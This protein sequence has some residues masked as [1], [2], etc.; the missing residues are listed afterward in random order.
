MKTWLLAFVIACAAADLSGCSSSSSSS[1]AARPCYGPGC[2]AAGG[3]KD[4][5]TSVVEN[6]EADASTWSPLCGP[7]SLGCLPDS[8]AGACQDVYS[9]ASP[10]EGDAGI[11]ALIDGGSPQASSATLTCRIFSL[12]DAIVRACDRAGSGAMGAP[13]RNT[14][15]CGN[16]YT[17]VAEGSAS[18]C[19]PYCCADAE[20]CP[21][22]T[23]CSPRSTVVARDGD[24]WTLGS[25]VPVCTPAENCPLADPFPCPQGKNCTCPVG[26]ACMIVRRHGLTA[27]VVP[28]GGHQGEFCPCDA[29]YVCS[30]ATFTCLQL[31]QL[32]SNSDTSQTSSQCSSGATC[33]ASNDVPLDWGVCN[34]VPLLIN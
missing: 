27:C 14:T 21:S 19:R 18:L 22:S 9:G 31:C 34:V 16:G 12:P 29:G 32:S 15:D 26:K 8:D 6:T 10:S 24:T 25:D 11:G 17:C 3:A 2:V 1:L 7:R 30:N 13:C 33:Q 5:A 4:A 23:Y 20:S 28:G